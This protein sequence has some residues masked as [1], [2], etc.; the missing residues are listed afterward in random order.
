MKK[1]ELIL[2][3]YVILFSSLTIKF[4]SAFNATQRFTVLPDTEVFQVRSLGL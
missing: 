2:Q 1:T 4:F 3:K